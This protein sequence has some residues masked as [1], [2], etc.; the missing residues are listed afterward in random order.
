LAHG[1]RRHVKGPALA[2]RS[3]VAWGV[4]GLGVGCGLLVAFGVPWAK[5][6]LGTGGLLLILLMAY[7]LE[8][9][10]LMRPP[11]PEGRRRSG[12]R[13]PSPPSGPPHEP[14]PP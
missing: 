9:A 6:L 11:S 12:E 5:A 2:F 13:P 8:Q 7:G 14:P 1:H 3:V 4:V 10:G